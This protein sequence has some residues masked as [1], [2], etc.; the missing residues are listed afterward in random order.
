M[1]ATFSAINVET[2]LEIRDLLSRFCH[3]LDRNLPRQWNDIFTPDAVIDAP[4]L[5]R[6]A[7]RAEIAKIPDMVQE[8]GGGAWRHFLHNIYIDLADNGRDL[9]IAAYC[10]VSDWRTQGNVIRCW[11][12]SARITRRRGLRIV[13][14]TLTMVGDERLSPPKATS[15]TIS[16]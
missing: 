12:L 9:L 6:F 15:Q 4:K 1:S 16:D 10:T 8:K 3:A 7:G 14:L 2:R 11:D 5:G 13:A